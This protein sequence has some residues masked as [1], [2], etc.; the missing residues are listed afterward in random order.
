MELGNA[1]MSSNRGNKRNVSSMGTSSNNHNNDGGKSSGKGKRQKGPKRHGTTN[2]VGSFK[3]EVKA[4]YYPPHIYKSFTEAQL[5]Q[6]KKLSAPH[7]KK[8][9]LAAATTNSNDDEPTGAGDEFGGYRDKKTKR[10]RKEKTD[11][12]E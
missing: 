12:D 6:H 3:E 2:A 8:R 9:A 4:Q 7:L 11:D 1:I 5:A 10:A